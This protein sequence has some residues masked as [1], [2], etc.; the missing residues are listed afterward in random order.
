MPAFADIPDRRKGFDAGSVL[1]RYW[2][3]IVKEVALLGYLICFPYD[4]A[5]ESNIHVHR[6]STPVCRDIG[7]I[8]GY[9]DVLPRISSLISDIQ[10]S[11][12]LPLFNPC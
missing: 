3:I 1:I 6:R 8:E 7:D 2:L 12:Y 9:R 11:I 4:V 5:T 10:Q